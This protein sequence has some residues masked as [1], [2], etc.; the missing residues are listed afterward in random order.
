MLARHRSGA[1]MRTEFDRVAVTRHDAVAVLSLN[2]PEVVNAISSRMI[3]GAMKAIDMIAAPEAGFRALIFT[4]EGR[5]FCSGANL[6]DAPMAGD[7]IPTGIGKRLDTLYH[8]LLRRLRALPMPIITAVNGPAVGI[9]LSFALMGDIVYAARSAYFLHSFARIGLVPDGGSTWLLPRLIGLARARELSFLAERLT[10]DK[11]LAWG[12]VN[13]VFDDAG[14]LPEA[15]ETARRLAEGPTV[16]LAALRCLYWESPH[17][18]Y[19]EQLELER[20]SQMRAG[21]TA[22]FIEGVSAFLQKREP[23]FSGK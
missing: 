13:A 10:A 1:T 9:G 14:L 17:N 12:L 3:E 22:D 20:L 21:G 5:G 7:D 16:A 23:H 2:H 6:T 4:G 15:L 8:P 19:D 11:A 18:S